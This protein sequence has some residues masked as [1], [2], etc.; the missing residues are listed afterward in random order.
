MRE[1]L[2]K[3]IVAMVWTITVFFVYHVIFAWQ[4]DLPIVNRSRF[5][6][7]SCRSLLLHQL[8][9]SFHSSSTNSNVSNCKISNLELWR[10]FDIQSLSICMCVC[11]LLLH[12]IKIQRLPSPS[13]VHIRA[14]FLNNAINVTCNISM[15]LEVRYI[16]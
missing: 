10:I 1:L 15:S 16:P 14:G 12:P 8:M 5:S 7:L 13:P 2:E 6:A 3:S 9:A 4:L 11:F